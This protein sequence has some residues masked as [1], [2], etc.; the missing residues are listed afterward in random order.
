MTVLLD[1]PASTDLVKNSRRLIRLRWL[2]GLALLTVTLINEYALGVNMP[3]R[4]LYSL[5]AAILVY[6]S[7]LW[8]VSRAVGTS[9]SQPIATGQ[10]VLDTLALVFSVHL[11]GGVESLATHFFLFYV[12]LAPILLPGRTGYLYVWLVIAA[13]VGVIGLEAGGVLPHYR[14]RPSLPPDLH[15]DPLYIAAK[16]SFFI[17]VALVTASLTIPIVREFRERE[18]RITT[19]YQSIRTLSSSLDLTQVLNQLA[20]AV[21][22]ALQAKGTSIRLVDETGAQL[23]IAAAYGL[24]KEYLD[25]GPVETESSPIDRSVLSGHPVIVH[26]VSQD[27]RFQYPSEILAE[28]IHSV[29]CVPLMGRRGP[30][31]VLRVYGHRPDCFGEEETNFVQAIAR[32]GATAIENALAFDEL[33]RTDQVKSQFVRAVTHELRSPVTGAQSLLRPMM[34]NLAGDLNEA[35]CEVLRRLSDRLDALQMLIDDL[36]DLAAGKVEGLER[37]LEPVSLITAARNVVDRLSGLAGEKSV[38]LCMAHVPRSIAVVAS[39]EGLE[40]ILLNLI[41]NAVKYTP[42]GGRV[43]VRLQRRDGE[44]VIRVTDTGIGIP[45]AD[46]PHLFEEF[47][48]ARNAKKAG[49]VGTGLG[50]AIVKNLVERYKGRISVQSTLD[51]GTTFTIVLPLAD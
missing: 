22:Q 6:N 44:A 24:S 34:R 26:D 1:V 28:G 11:T 20:C 36:L 17:T 29:L 19:L 3:A 37:E 33:R 50:L 4:A 25:K 8:W 5:G 2:A 13:V 48:R 40:R 21:T 14:V 12:L 51:K 38:D 15:R 10:V 16:L 32:Q 42:A 30:L 43:D 46:L 49:I 35:Q 23:K 9:W 45:D 31:G 7:L 39:E 41:G 18:Q 27:G 47:F